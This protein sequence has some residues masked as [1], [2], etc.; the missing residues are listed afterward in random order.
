MFQH[1]FSE[2]SIFIDVLTLWLELSVSTA[3][4]LC[5]FGSSAPLFDWSF[6]CVWWLSFKKIRCRYT[7]VL[8]PSSDI[9]PSHVKLVLLRFSNNLGRASDVLLLNNFLLHR[10][11][12]LHRHGTLFCHRYHL[13]GLNVLGLT[14]FRECCCAV[15]LPVHASE[16]Y[17]IRVL[18]PSQLLVPWVLAN[19][20]E[21][22]LPGWLIDHVRDASSEVNLTL[23]VFTPRSEEIPESA[24]KVHVL[25]IFRHQSHHFAS[26]LYCLF[27]LR[28]CRLGLSK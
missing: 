28:V 15:P 25:I 7:L 17:K 6:D 5:H 20:L 19:V 10:V 27:K 12:S 13:E 24:L 23:C 2:Y 11:I 3:A 21:A 18:S 26:F 16:L 9:L 14:P 8:Q 1:E 22:T 4:L